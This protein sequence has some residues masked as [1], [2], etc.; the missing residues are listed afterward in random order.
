[1]FIGLDGGTI[2]FAVHIVRN[3][4]IDRVNIFVGEQLLIII[5]YLIDRGEIICVPIDL[6][7][8]QGAVADRD[9]E[10]EL[11][12]GGEAQQLVAARNYLEAL[13][14]LEFGFRVPL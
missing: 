8:R 12:L 11:E 9:E 14:V 3:S 13:P 6:F 7:G 2:N 10:L 5:C 4:N 1:M